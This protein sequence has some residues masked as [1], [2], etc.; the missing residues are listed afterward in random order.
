MKAQTIGKIWE[1]RHNYEDPNIGAF[2]A[3]PIKKKNCGQ[4]PKYNRDDIREAILLVPTYR[5]RTLWKLASAIG[6]GLGTL[7]RMKNDKGDN[8]IKPHLNAV[9]PHLEGRHDFARALDAVA[10]LDMES[11]DFHGYF[12]SV[13][14]DKKW[15]FLTEA[16]LNLYLVPGEPVPERSIGH[17]IHI[18][19]VMFFAAIGR[20]RYNNTGECTFDGK[21]GL[22]IFVERVAAQRTSVRRPAGMM[23]TK[24][25][26]VMTQ[27]Y[28]EM[29]IKKVLPAI[30]LKWPDWD[31]GIIIQQD[32]ASLHIKQD[33]AAFAAA[34]AGNWQIQLLKH[35]RPNL[36]IQTLLIFPFSGLSNQL[37]G[38]MVL[39][40]RLMA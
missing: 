27:V 13:H 4:K 30:K 29:L 25:V 34:A 20:P 12:D 15:F 8:I 6:I 5:K 9:R 21:V 1:T 31:H 7:H 33:D 16:Q 19:K 36:Q 39:P 14:M 40:L 24:P 35:R 2:L 28:R 10:N 11:G 26:S 17:K 3:S 22:W 37:S 23:E 18:L 38:I 32:G